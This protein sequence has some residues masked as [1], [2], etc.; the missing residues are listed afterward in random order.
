MALV[1]E[2][3][4]ANIR[5]R[6]HFTM[7][8]PV[9]GLGNYRKH[10]GPM[11]SFAEIGFVAEPSDGWDSR[12]LLPEEDRI[13][14]EK[15]DWVRYAFLGMLDVLVFQPPEPLLCIRVSLTAARYTFESSRNAFRM[16]GRNAAE[17]LLASAKI[18]Y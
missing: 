12:V 10:F 2:D 11:W 7:R 5:N 18:V 3:W 9:S 14:M 1:L 6:R 8:H 15:D 4:L 13:E 17:V 16:A